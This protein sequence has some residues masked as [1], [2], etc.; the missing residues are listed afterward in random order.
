MSTAFFMAL[1]LSALRVPELTIPLI[2]PVI[3]GLIMFVF[4]VAILLVDAAGATV[5]V[6][7]PVE[8]VTVTADV[9]DA[10]EKRPRAL[11]NPVRAEESTNGLAPPV[12]D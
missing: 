8:L 10:L 2:K 6:V 7:D 12:Y 4:V 11:L 9:D 5:V 1:T 3:T